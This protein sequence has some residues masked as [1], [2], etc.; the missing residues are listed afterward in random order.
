MYVRMYVALL[1]HQCV[2]TLV[3][4]QKCNVA[5]TNNAYRYY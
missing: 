1:T 3:T 2:V 5:V 4:N